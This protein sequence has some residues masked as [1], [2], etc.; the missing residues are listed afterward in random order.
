MHR[1]N[2]FLQGGELRFS[3]VGTNPFSAYNEWYVSWSENCRADFGQKCQPVKGK[4][5][6]PN[7]ECTNGYIYNLSSDILKT[8]SAMQVHPHS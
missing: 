5:I 4:I 2:I 3:S 6:R 1:V 8:N 7:I